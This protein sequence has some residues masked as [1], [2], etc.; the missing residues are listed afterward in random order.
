MFLVGPVQGRSLEEFCEQG[1]RCALP[2]HWVFSLF[3]L[4][5]IVIVCF[6]MFLSSYF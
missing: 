1:S 5:F 6:N 2:G 4:V 3:Q